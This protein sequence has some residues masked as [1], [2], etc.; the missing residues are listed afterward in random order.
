MCIR[1]SYRRLPDGKAI[2]LART[3]NDPVDAVYLRETDGTVTRAFV[4][5]LAPDGLSLIHI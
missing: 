1:D 5:A 3:A 2:F 4:P